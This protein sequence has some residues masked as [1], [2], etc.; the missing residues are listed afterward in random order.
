MKPFA[1]G[2]IKLTQ[3][4][5]TSKIAD[6]V[7]LSPETSG[8]ISCVRTDDKNAVRWFQLFFP[9]AILSIDT[10]VSNYTE[11]SGQVRFRD[12]IRYLIASV[13]IG[14]CPVIF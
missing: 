13:S 14:S 1:R 7:V 11:L 6:G 2:S 5:L 4:T 10:S 3:N 12:Q 9:I 8:R